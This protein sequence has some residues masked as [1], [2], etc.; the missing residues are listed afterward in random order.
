[1]K[2]AELT[3]Y[4][5]ADCHFF[6]SAPGPFIV[7]WKGTDGRACDTGCS[8]YESGKCSAYRKIVQPGKSRPGA[9]AGETVREEAA[10]RGVSISQV[11]RERAAAA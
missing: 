6:L 7:V 5:D 9:V 8:W 11:R 2:R 3:E 4:R 10:R 1:M